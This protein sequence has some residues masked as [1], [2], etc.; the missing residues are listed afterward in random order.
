VLPSWLPRLL[1][2][3]LVTGCG[4]ADFDVTQDVPEQRVPGS[5]LPA[6]L[7]QFFDVPVEIQIQ[8]QIA[9]RET[10]PVDSVRLTS[11]VLD[12]TATAEGS[13]DMDD[14]AFV[15]RVDIFVESSR[16][17]SSLPRVLVASVIDPGL[18]RRLDFEPVP[19]L[20]LL[21]YVNEGARMTAD[22]QGSAPEDDVTYA[23]R[24]VFRVNPL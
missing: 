22:G 7:G 19:D 4:I 16:S 21:P 12:I 23:G 11:L 15:E 8:E 5:P 13:D 20:N 3:L 17:G 6:I 2:L 1:V 18:T 14:F 9:A 24:S 10:G